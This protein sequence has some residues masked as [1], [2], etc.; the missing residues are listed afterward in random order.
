MTCQI[1]RKNRRVETT[2]VTA[3]AAAKMDGY[4]TAE[5][6]NKAALLL[7][8]CSRSQTSP[9]TSTAGRRS[10]EG[11]S[12]LDTHRRRRHCRGGMLEPKP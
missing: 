3:V 9:T 2:R 1:E 7:C 12:F 4:V 6:S 8:F 10:S 11:S 5:N